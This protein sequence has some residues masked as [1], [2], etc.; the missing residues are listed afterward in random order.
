VATRPCPASGGRPGLQPVQLHHSMGDQAHRAQGWR[1]D[2]HITRLRVHRLADPR[3]VHHGR[4]LGSLDAQGIACVSRLTTRTRQA[5]PME[6]IGCITERR[7]T[8]KW[9]RSFTS[10]CR[11]SFPAPADAP[12]MSATYLRV[13]HRS[14]PQPRGICRTA[15]PG[16]RSSPG[17]I[18]N[19]V[20][21]GCCATD[22][23]DGRQ[24]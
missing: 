1:A 15:A 6:I 21:H 9:R 19:S 17:E 22:G 4:R 23:E 10:T 11:R 7:P 14:F 5:S 13:T 24:S 12:L 18:N 8:R 2:R 16:H 3:S 20:W